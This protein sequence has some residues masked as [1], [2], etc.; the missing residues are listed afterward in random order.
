MDNNEGKI[1]WIEDDDYYID[2]N[3][4]RYSRNKWRKEEMEEI[5]KSNKD[6]YGCCDCCMCTG[7]IEC[8]NCVDS[9]FSKYCSNSMRLIYCENCHNCTDCEN[10]SNCKNC[11]RCEKC[12][13]C[14][15][16]ERCE[17]CN[18]CRKGKCLTN[19]DRTQGE[20]LKK[21][22]MEKAEK[23]QN[24]YREW[25]LAQEPEEILQHTYEYTMR[26]DILLKLNDMELDKAQLKELLKSPDLMD[27]I[28]QRYTKFDT[29]YMELIEESVK[30]HAKPIQHEEELE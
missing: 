22:L 26:E 5:V 10:C 7:C 12:K 2:I 29:K 25:L 18:N 11:E 17:E 9:F 19:K 4:N 13:N 6:C 28:Y 27:G 24:I 3:G 8:D 14:E 20:E 1:F 15:K 16:C 30:Q 23:E 21:Q